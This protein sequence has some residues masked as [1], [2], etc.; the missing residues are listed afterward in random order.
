MIRPTTKEIA[1]ILTKIMPI[2]YVA[3]I[4]DDLLTIDQH[5][6]CSDR[7]SEIVPDTVTVTIAGVSTPLVYHSSGEHAGWWVGTIDGEVVRYRFNNVP[8]S[9]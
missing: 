3:D 4:I 2:E 7:E 1:D 5:P 9:G 8:L 6:A